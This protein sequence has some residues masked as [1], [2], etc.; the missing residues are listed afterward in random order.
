MS[1]KSEQM[2]RENALHYQVLTEKLP[3]P[4]LIHVAGIL[5]YMNAECVRL[6]G[7]KSAEEFIGTSIMEVIHP[8]YRAIAFERV[9]RILHGE[10]NVEPVELKL[11][12]RDGSE[13]WIETTGIAFPLAGEQ[14]IYVVGKDIKDRKR[15]EAEHLRRLVELEALYQLSNSVSLANSLEQVFEVAMQSIFSILKVQRA[16][17]L[18]LDGDAKMRFRAWNGLSETYRQAAD[19]HSPWSVEEINPDPIFVEDIEQ[20]VEMAYFR[21]V[22]KAEGIRAFGFV[23]LVQEGRL[24]GK[25]MVYCDQPHQFTEAE[26]QLAKTIALHIAFAIER[27]QSAID[28]RI[29]ASAFETQEGILVTN[30]QNVIIKVNRAFTAI[31][32]YAS[33]EVLGQTPAVLKSGVQDAEFYRLLWE[34]LN[35]DLFWE[36]EI[37]N[38]RK[39]GSIYPE[40]LGITAV[41]NNSKKIINYVATFT[42][43]TRQK[44]A[45]EEIF[46]LAYYDPLTQLPN[47]RL[48]FDRL[49]QSMSASVRHGQHGAVIFIDLDYFKTLNDTKGH[50]M[51]DLMLIEVAKRLQVSVRDFDTVSRLGGDEFVVMI[52][53]LS[54]NKSEAAAH[55]EQVA[56]KIRVALSQPYYLLD[57]E[58]HST[59][60]I[61]VAL[62]QGRE[63]SINEL[64]KH[65][66]IAM[67]QSKAAGRNAV[68]FYDVA[69]QAALEERMDMEDALRKAI[70]R[71]EFQLH[72]QIQV[73][74][75]HRIVGAEALLRWIHPE[76]GTISPATFIPLAEE[77]G[78]IL[79]IGEWVLH[80]AC[81]QIQRWAANPLTRHLRVAVNVSSVQ[82][83]QEGFVVQVQ[84]AL[85]VSGIDPQCLKLELTESLMLHN[86]EDTI[87]KMHS[88]KALGIGFSMDDFGTG[89]SSLSYL[90][91]LPLDQLKIDQSFVRDLAADHNDKAIVQAI[92]TMAEAFGLNVIA[93]G[94]ETEA[95][96]SQLTHKGCHSFQGYLFGKPMPI[97]QLD[98]MLAE[99]SFAL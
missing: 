35:R 26:I 99:K 57:H 31:T 4:M 72:Y 97:N 83:A 33:E 20:N 7:G 88:L 3:M 21:P 65:A 95:Q 79:E 56:Q 55:A 66:D 41:L 84:R 58:F 94:V 30:A 46:S 77:T 37:W 93:E 25:F 5:K 48:L 2:E 49:N 11:T 70:N 13:T 87:K 47:R 9:Q 91:R 85:Q 12:C 59:P 16:A 44:K 78:L 54:S 17:I 63:E 75:S 69:M 73:D 76:R 53:S 34:T 43:V 62:Y 74:G 28:L 45:E 18:L 90:K 89:F 40:R 10:E 68:R 6:L 8:D 60:S 23:P 39:D 38:R 14:A 64:I 61:G 82:F 67:Y 71:E 27:T 52:D 1:K 42:D 92:I 15:I 24:L 98:A 96:R 80:T 19:G 22:A 51:G 29:A 50:E 32:G 86:V 36:G 81:V